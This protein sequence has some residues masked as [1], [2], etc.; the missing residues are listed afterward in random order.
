MVVENLNN[1]IK[2]IY[3]NVGIDNEIFNLDYILKDFNKLFDFMDK[4]Q[5]NITKKSIDS[6]K[7][8]SP[9]DTSLNNDVKITPKDTSLNNDVKITPKDT[10]S[11]NDIKLIQ[12]DTSSNNDIK[13]TS[14]DISMNTNTHISKIYYQNI[15]YKLNTIKIKQSENLNFS[16][17]HNSNIHENNIINMSNLS[18]EL[19]NEN[20]SYLILFFKQKYLINKINNT[21]II[22]NLFNKNSQVIK[23]KEYFK[24]GTYDYMLYNDSTL[25]IPMINK[26]I[27]DNNYGTSFNLYTPKI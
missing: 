13:I 12:K 24:I 4:S 8:I 21:F 1:K 17:L 10:S 26:K 20:S 23:N 6:I 14:K 22:T 18:F 3:S 16:N 15:F 7:K 11:N 9:K 5:N 25:I 19:D 27:F 2:N